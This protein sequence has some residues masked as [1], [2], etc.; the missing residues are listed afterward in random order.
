MPAGC[1][2]PSAKPGGLAARGWIGFGWECTRRRAGFWGWP[3]GAAGRDLGAVGTRKGVGLPAE[4]G[5]E[6]WFWREGLSRETVRSIATIGHVTA[7]T[8]SRERSWNRWT[9]DRTDERRR[10]INGYNANGY[11]LRLTG[12]YGM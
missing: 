12:R 3:V 9:F 2:L 8:G 11:S 1:W 6:A 4:G 10:A 5:G 7:K